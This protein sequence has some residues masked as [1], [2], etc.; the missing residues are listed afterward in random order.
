[1]GKM[2]IL[3]TNQKKFL[4]LVVNEPY[5]LRHFYWTGGT[6]LAEFYL[7]HRES[8]DIDLFSEQ[9]IHLPSV[10]KFVKIAAR[11]MKITQVVYKQFLGL[12]SYAFKMP[13][14]I[15]KVDFN[16]YPFP[17]INLGTK[18][19]GLAID[20]LEDIAA[21]KVHTISMKARDRDFVDLYFILQRPEFSL[22]N[23][24]SLA[25]AKF[26]WPI[27]PVQLGQALIKIVTVK[28]MPQMFVPFERKK[29]EEFFLQ[30]AKSLKKEIF[31]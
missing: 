6:V 8:Y 11:Q 24:I 28:E 31:L 21:N 30:L 2:S 22:D 23:L 7:K 25:R 5:L 20:S 26:D 4:E 19:K 13:K 9:E 10:T 29:M 15:L 1:M 3:D 14:G 18:W 27:D 17:R 16:Y 12:H